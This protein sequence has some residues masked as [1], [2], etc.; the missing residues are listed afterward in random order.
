[1]ASESSD[2]VHNTHK[3]ANG[4]PT[5]PHLSTDTPRSTSQEGQDEADVAQTFPHASGPGQ[6]DQPS[7]LGPAEEDTSPVV[8]GEEGQF[9]T[10]PD[11]SALDAGHNLR[12]A[13]P[14]ESHNSRLLSSDYEG[15]VESKSV[16]PIAEAEIEPPFADNGPAEETRASTQSI[17]AAP[18][19]A[20]GEEKVAAAGQSMV[21]EEQTDMDDFFPD[22]IDR[23]NT[24]PDV[25]PQN[26]ATN[27]ETVYGQ[28]SETIDQSAAEYSDTRPAGGLPKD[29]QSPWETLDEGSED[30]DGNLTF[31]SEDQRA[32]DVPFAPEAGNRYEEGVPLVESF[33]MEPED[34]RS[35]TQQQQDGEAQAIPQSEAADGGRD[36]SSDFVPDSNGH[37]IERRPIDRKD[38]AQVM[39]S[40]HFQPKPQ[41]VTSRETVE[42]QSFPFG[43]NDN[44]ESF[45]DQPISDETKQPE[46]RSIDQGAAESNQ[47]E[48]LDAMWKAAL[49][50]DELLDDDGLLEDEEAPA[51]E[52]GF[53]DDPNDALL[54]DD[55][56]ENQEQPYSTRPLTPT[57]AAVDARMKG[58]PNAPVG[59]SQKAYTNQPNPYAPHQPSSTYLLGGLEPGVYGTNSGPLTSQR[60]T[61][62]AKAQSF[63]D[64]SRG[65]YKS[66]YDLPMDI[67]RPKKKTFT[68]Q[69]LSLGTQTSST[70]PPPPP[71]SSSMHGSQPESTQGSMPSFVP[72]KGAVQTSPLSA[73]GLR[74][75]SASGAAAVQPSAPTLNSKGSTASF[76]EE[77]PV[78]GRPR[79]ATRTTNYT[80]PQNPP[81][82]P[83][84]PPIARSV[85]MQPA[86]STSM[87]APGSSLQQQN[88]PA[89]VSQQPSDPYAQYQMHPPE[90]VDPYA[91]APQTLLGPGKVPPPS[92]SRYS[93]APPGGGASRPTTGPR[94][95]PAPPPQAPAQQVQVRNRYASS[96]GPM[97]ASPNSL[98]FQPRTSSPLAQPTKQIV[99]PPQRSAS[100]GP[101]LARPFSQ[102]AEELRSVG[103]T[104]TP[105]QDSQTDGMQRND[106]TIS[107]WPNA[108]SP[109][110]SE[111]PASP[112]PVATPPRNLDRYA[113]SRGSSIGA[114]PQPYPGPVSGFDA[115]QAP[116]SRI[117]QYPSGPSEGDAPFEAPRRSMTQSPGKQ[118]SYAQPGLSPSKA[119]YPRSA[120]VLEPTS[121]RMG[122]S[123][124]RVTLPAKATR[125]SRGFSQSLNFILPND[126]REH[127]P[128]QRWRGCPIFHFGF[129]GAAVSCFP[130]QVPRYNAG[131]VLPM[132][133]SSPGEVKVRNIK[134]IAPLPEYLVKYP[135]PLK[136][137]NK[138]KD[139]LSWLTER[140]AV[141][142]KGS[143]LP[144]P[145]NTLPDPRKRYEEKL[146]LWRTVKI[147]VEFDGNLDGKDV[148]VKAIRNIVSPE[149]AVSE[150][151][152]SSRGVGVDLVGISSRHGPRAAEP[153]DVDALE[154]LRQ[155][156]LLGEREKAV[157][158]AVDKRLWAHAMLI[159][160]TMSKEIWK[161]VAQ[162]F[163]RQEVKT[164]GENTESL[165]ALYEVFAGNWEESIDE[166]V[167]PSARAGLQ[168]V[169]KAAS[170][171]PTRNALDG[172]DRWRETLGLILSNRSPG[173]NQ[174]LFSLGR[175]LA[176]YGR[177]EAAHI[178]YLFSRGS[179]LQI[180]FGG[181]EDP[182]TN[183]TLL[184]ADHFTQP[185]DFSRDEDAIMLTEVYEFAVSVLAGQPH[186]SMP[187]LQAY[188]LHRARTLAENGF[189]TEAQQYCDAIGTTLK[190]TTKM[191][192]YYHNYLFAAVD[193]LSLRLRQGPGDASSSWKPSMEKVSGSVWAKFN[194][195]VAGDDSDAASTGSVKNDGD[196]GPFA[197]VSGTPTIS[198]A[199][200]TSDLYG[201]YGG[202]QTFNAP[203]NSRYAPN[204]QSQYAP[205]TSLD[206][207]GRSSQE[208][209][210][211]SPYAPFNNTQR[212][213]SYEPTASASS[214]YAPQSQP[215]FDSYMQPQQSHGY[216]PIQPE[217]SYMPAAPSEGYQP[218]QANSYMPTPPLQESSLSNG[219]QPHVPE[220]VDSLPQASTGAYDSFST[221]SPNA[222]T[223]FDHSSTSNG[224]YAPPSAS[225]GY[226][227]PTTTSGYE[228]PSS[229][230]GYE[231]PSYQPYNPSSPTT[232]SPTEDQ[233]RKKKSFMDDDDEDDL[234]ARAAALKLG[235]SASANPSNKSANDA[236]AD[237]AFRAA[238]EADAARDKE[239]A[240]AEKK[241]WLSGW[242]GG[243][244]DPSAIGGQAP[245]GPI[246]AKLGEASSF[247]YDEQLKKWVNKKGGTD[248]SAPKATPPPPRSGPPSR[249]VSYNTPA[250]PASTP[251]PPP[252][253]PAAAAPGFG[254]TSHPLSAGD[255]LPAANSRPSTGSGTPAR[256][257]SPAMP[258]SL[259]GSASGPPSGPPSRPPTG[260]STASSIDDLLGAPTARK[261]N[262]IKGKK[263]GRGYVDIMAKP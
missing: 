41:P 126:G 95:S 4:D 170:A 197:K 167:P 206:L 99:D 36:F 176:G 122:D 204:S 12:D 255:G 169:S 209:S 2:I 144:T 15:A 45:F 78:A 208:S 56:L 58:L 160:S 173:D 61:M 247:Y 214:S 260:L 101:A 211:S 134:E 113:P 9:S 222:S 257:D 69:P 254:P 152:D 248:T 220:A 100:T 80:P 221:Q 157:W 132:I 261:G 72:P 215:S 85:S 190:S 74:P 29:E 63:V 50:D 16:P 161:Q 17:S 10:E 259:A 48:D 166:L 228:P 200:S 22:S 151:Q 6:D 137:K 127:D 252:Q 62:T 46:S 39:D 172:L 138:K 125:H 130:R 1:M 96:P 187:H 207:P 104:S 128:L 131:H 30:L 146:L 18:I 229:T 114:P 34:Q 68:S 226:E 224:G 171:G 253:M 230:S 153:I 65:G 148:A 192:P 40:L 82:A 52:R 177:I 241:G 258:P 244:K 147:F 71:R 213:S 203:S 19:P 183:I 75:P 111:F 117:V 124:P 140:I 216:Q 83:P 27:P 256:S 184:G 180:N 13:Q 64:Q 156:L 115:S 110:V 196:F 250:P 178:C 92:T 89:R 142:E 11:R 141:L 44:A 188:K 121:P 77:L 67:T 236:A 47:G 76:F 223:L 202:N 227:P 116:P 239:K 175:L 198:R 189:R 219:Y 73:N 242:F 249:S 108:G 33:L 90:K 186:M 94:Y 91:P 174:A 26:D 149:L 54:D 181:V 154:E 118:V 164:V 205:R 20:E 38:T 87:Q 84:P 103:R 159:S 235:P 145:S 232:D 32:Q 49:G 53:F 182:Q 225:T 60:P 251:T 43:E 42:A 88:P 143:W 191:S 129:G 231:P 217:T 102:P 168:M 105:V 98:Q 233:P 7:I 81:I 238:A 70:M 133:K 112:P 246:R 237:A 163:V 37:T 14:E 24:F 59:S 201:A 139:V 119:P 5:T 8:M 57:R 262:T 21:W 107:A 195:F 86:P 199:G 23:S 263:K 135:G 31:F 179:G 245:A 243:K 28:Q 185:F 234:A 25:Q 3:N 212:R 106:E 194:S 165:A 35:Q 120:S 51:D 240:S 136:S 158:H 123:P 210:R 155:N 55:F 66:P 162:E 193:E 93:P 109:T 79:P 150:S 97:S 218:Q